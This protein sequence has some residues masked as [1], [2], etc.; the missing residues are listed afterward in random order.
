MD[1]RGGGGEGISSKFLSGGGGVFLPMCISLFGGKTF[2]LVLGR[3]GIVERTERLFIKPGET[4]FP[5]FKRFVSL[6]KWLGGEDVP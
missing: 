1:S 6:T 4:F 5:S 3:G 2:S